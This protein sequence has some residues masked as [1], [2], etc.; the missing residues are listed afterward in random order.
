MFHHC[1]WHW[2]YDGQGGKRQRKKKGKQ[3]R[4]CCL[5][6][7]GTYSLGEKQTLMNDSYKKKLSI[8]C[9]KC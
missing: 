8:S 5:W 2:G 9:D 7:H 3:K 1:A 6:C 4:K